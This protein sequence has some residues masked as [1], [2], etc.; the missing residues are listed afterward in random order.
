MWCS[1]NT[2]GFVELYSP[3]IWICTCKAADKSPAS[4][5]YLLEAS[6][7]CMLAAQPVFCCA[8]L[9]VL[10][11]KERKDCAFWRHFNE[12]PNITPGCPVLCADMLFLNLIVTAHESCAP[13]C[14]SVRKGSCPRQIV[15]EGLFQL[16][17]VPGSADAG[18]KAASNSPH[19]FLQDFCKAHG[20]AGRAL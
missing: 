15:G 1:I 7:S 19:S 3:T 12:K 5:L 16:C 20:P 9:S 4:G 8:I 6:L 11:E 10:T 2:Y 18:C 14:R 13:V 17:R